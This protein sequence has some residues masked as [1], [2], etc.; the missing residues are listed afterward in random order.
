MSTDDKTTGATEYDTLIKVMAE[1]REQVKKAGKN[2]VAALFKH[3]FA[4]NPDVT[5]IGW[6]QYTPHFNDGDP[7][8]FNVHEFSYTTKTG[9]D[10]AEV[11]S[12]YA[13]EDDDGAG[14]KGT[15]GSQR[16]RDGEIREAVKA[17]A[18][19]VDDDV[20]EAAFGDGVMVIATP[21]G[22]HVNEY[23]HD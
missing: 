9:V 6:T 3:F 10:F 2:A 5:G 21:A 22:F 15:Y 17:I 8:E 13:G 23:S 11:D 12:I 20:F 16:G 14:W 4:T 1:A 19:A 18:R 7:C